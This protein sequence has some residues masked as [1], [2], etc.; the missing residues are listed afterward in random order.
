MNPL[1]G[2]WLIGLTFLVA[3]ALSVAHLPVGRPE[4][5]AWVRPAW[6]PF[7]LFFWMLE[8]PHRVG[9]LAVWTFGLL[10]DVLLSEPL[11]LNGLLLTLMALLGKFSY[12]RLRMANALQQAIVLLVLVLVLELGKDLAVSLAQ[13]TPLSAQSLAGATATVFLWPLLARPLRWAAW[14]AG[15]A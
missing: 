5:L 14:R 6:V 12:E 2:G 15:T 1:R 4:W 9:L 11:G 8:R 3:A 13:G 10:L 7:V